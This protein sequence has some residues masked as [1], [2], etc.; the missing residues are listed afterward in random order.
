MRLVGVLFIFIFIPNLT[1]IAEKYFA[2]V[3]GLL[4]LSTY[5]KSIF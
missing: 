4:Y 2:M 1:P 3:G 5:H